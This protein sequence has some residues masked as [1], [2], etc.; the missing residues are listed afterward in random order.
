MKSEVVSVP[1]MVVIPSTNSLSTSVKLNVNLALI[2]YTAGMLVDSHGQSFM[3]PML[4]FTRPFFSFCN[5][6]HPDLI[7]RYPWES[8]YS[9]KTSWKTCPEFHHT[10]PVLW[11][12]HAPSWWEYPLFW[13]HQVFQDLFG[14]WPAHHSSWKENNCFTCKSWY[15]SWQT[16]RC[17]IQLWRLA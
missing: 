12:Q 6:Y 1:G 4:F 10:N 16:G 14:R 2:S 17:R 15:T 13:Q 5:Y 7:S 3:K 11:R 9:M 8:N